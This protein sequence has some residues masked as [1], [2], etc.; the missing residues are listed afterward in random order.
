[1]KVLA[2]LLSP[3]DGT[4]AGWYSGYIKASITHSVDLGFIPLSN[5]TKRLYTLDS[6]LQFHL[7][8]VNS[9]QRLEHHLWSFSWAEAL[10]LQIYYCNCC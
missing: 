4:L 7:C 3:T 10:F 9:R 5:N 1:M 8:V 2:I 6:Y